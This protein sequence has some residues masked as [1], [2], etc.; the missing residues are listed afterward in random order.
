MPSNNDGRSIKFK[1]D[2]QQFR[3]NKDQA[4]PLVQGFMNLLAKNKVLTV[5]LGRTGH[6]W[7]EI[8]LFSLA[9]APNLPSLLHNTTAKT[10][11]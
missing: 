11:R 4:S 1:A 7:V 8:F 9:C 3:L 10:T 6:T 2:Q 5:P